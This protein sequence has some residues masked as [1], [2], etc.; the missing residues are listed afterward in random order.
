[1]ISK[2][3][4]KSLAKQINAEMYSAYLYLS[5]SSY[6]KFV[7]LDGAAKWLMMQ[8]GEEMTH[9][10]KF[11]EYLCSHGEHVEF[12]AI[13]KP[14]AQFQSLKHIFEAVLEH[15]KKVTRLIG[16]LMDQANTENDHATKVFLQWFV[17]EQVEEEESAMEILAKLGMAGEH[18]GALYM[19]DRE[20]G[21][22]E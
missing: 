8:A 2:K 3:M 6:A 14:P 13:D 17:T 5:M 19:L 18:K 22:R 10:R 4:S 15:E 7:N 9:A 20:L 1:M 12:E 11:Y 21:A 16:K